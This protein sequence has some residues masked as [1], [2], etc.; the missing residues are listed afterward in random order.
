MKPYNTL[1]LLDVLCIALTL[2]VTLSLLRNSNCY[3]AASSSTRWLSIT[4][5]FCLAEYYLA[6]AHWYQTSET[7]PSIL[8]VTLSVALISGKFV[9]NRILAGA[10]LVLLGFI[11]GFIRADVAVILHA[12]F[13]L[14]VLFSPKAPIPLGRI[15]QLAVSLFTALV[16][17]CVQ[18]Y[19]MR[20]RF[21]NAKYGP[22]GVVQ[23]AVN[24]HPGM[25]LTMLLALSPYW[26]LISLIATRRYQPNTSTRMLLTASVLYLAVWTVVGLLDEVR[27]FLP[28]AFA[29]IPA[30]VMALIGRIPESNRSYRSRAV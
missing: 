4:G 3:R 20:I 24:L 18:L 22:E 19:L 12:G 15:R 29:L 30:T 26:L 21:P 13:F 1:T 14:A 8:I 6:W 17:G 5:V 9:Q 10:L 2:C 27:I 11:Q 16:A 7:I 28:F 23:F 25:W